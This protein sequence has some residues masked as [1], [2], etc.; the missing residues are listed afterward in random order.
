MDVGMG[1]ALP[2]AAAATAPSTPSIATHQ[3]AAQHKG[4]GGV[5]AGE[6]EGKGGGPAGEDEG[7][8]GVPSAEDKGKGGVPAGEDKGKGGG[9]GAD[10]AVHPP[11]S[12]S[13]L[14]HPGLGV[15]AL[16]C[17]CLVV[18]LVVRCCCRGRRTV[19]LPP[20]HPYH[21]LPARSLTPTSRTSRRRRTSTSLRGSAG[22]AEHGLSCPRSSRG[23]A[24]Q[25]QGRRVQPRAAR[26]V[27]GEQRGCACVGGCSARRRRRSRRGRIG[28]SADDLYFALARSLPTVRI[29]TWCE[30]TPATVVHSRW[31]VLS[32]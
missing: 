4:K 1:G 30:D 22:S 31:H 28:A 17:L 24:Q 16:V 32:R 3:L 21:A 12:V 13:S 29:R 25:G 19:E 27:V 8:G 9:P 26:P 15:L 14:I 18:L 6:D 2:R 10:D 11:L 20:D 23:Q 7:K 5:P